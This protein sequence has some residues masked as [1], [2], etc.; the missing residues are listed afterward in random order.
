MKP[1]HNHLRYLVGYVSDTSK[2]Y[3]P[4]FEDIAAEISYI[5]D[6]LK[7]E[8][9]Y[10]VDGINCEVD[11]AYEEM[12]ASY[13][14]TDTPIKVLAYHGIQSFKPG[15]VSAETAHEIGMKLAQELWGD[16]FV[17]LVATH[18]NKAHFHN[19]FLLCSTS[20][21]DGS[22]YH[23]CTATYWEMRNANDRLCR[24][25]GLSVP[26]QPYGKGKEYV[27]RQAEL[28]GKPTYSS[29]MREDID[30][31]ISQSMFMPQFFKAL[32]RMGYEI[33]TG[34]YLAIR[35]RGGQR[36]RRVKTLGENYS[37]AAIALRLRNNL[38]C[39]APTIYKYNRIGTRRYR[40]SF[41]ERKK[42]P[43]LS[44]LR[45]LYF[46]YLYRMGILP[47]QK[48]NGMRVS[49]LL[50]EDIIK[51]D[52]FIAQNDFLHRYKIDTPEQLA[53]H[54]AD[55]EKELSVLDNARAQ[56]RGK[57][58]HPPSDE[59]RDK[60]RSEIAQITSQMRSVRKEI[61]LCDAIAEQS[62]IMR[63]KLRAVAEAE[64]QR[65]A[66]QQKKQQGRKRGG[67]R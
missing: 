4:D 23:A 29:L 52:K 6:E 8:Q 43:R 51:L 66:E 56:L 17:V 34:K 39:A 25:Y 14:A 59:V 22:R 42:H 31:A 20:Y 38:R 53:E 26:E 18:L 24:E 13:R 41:S 10:Y 65:Q 3:N 12:L 33:K 55:A 60:L 63:E 40:G 9:R 30:L 19:H 61:S 48:K 47:Q 54:K 62:E 28:Q 50:R 58:K 7:T 27:E 21:V 15:E 5:G 44:G 35:G 36:F 16:K 32:E 1:V 11:T 57:A 64:R 46:S 45:A 67:A 49:P 2:T 37:E